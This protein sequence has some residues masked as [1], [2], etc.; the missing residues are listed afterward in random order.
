[1]E[2]GPKKKEKKMEMKIS[3]L[4]SQSF[5]QIISNQIQ[6]YTMANSIIFTA[7]ICKYIMIAFGLFSHFEYCTD[8]SENFCCHL[9]I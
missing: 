8:I 5:I 7:A 4:P 9:G 3:E 2:S 1:M 6:G